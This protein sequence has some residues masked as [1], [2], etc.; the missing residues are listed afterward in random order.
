MEFLCFLFIYWFLEIGEYI[1]FSTIC[2]IS[3]LIS[4]DSW[5]VM[6]FHAYILIEANTKNI[7]KIAYINVKLTLQLKI[8][9]YSD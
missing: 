6:Y 2:W 4:Y 9:T 8:F 5:I 7:Y 3:I 1:N